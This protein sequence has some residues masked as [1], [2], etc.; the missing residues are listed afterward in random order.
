LAALKT[1]KATGLAR[2]GFWIFVCAIGYRLFERVFLAL[3][4]IAYL[5]ACLV[6]ECQK[7]GILR[8]RLWDFFLALPAIA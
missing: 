1:K 3:S 7:E 6:S 8:S 5:S 2:G 4:A